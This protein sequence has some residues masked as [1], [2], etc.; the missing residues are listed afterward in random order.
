M[1]GAPGRRESAGRLRRDGLMRVASAGHAVFA[2]LLIFVGIQGLVAGNF[3]VIWQPVPKGVPARGALVY[4]CSAVS[5]ASGIGLLFRRTASA[6]S[7]ALVALLV[8]WFVVWRVPAVFAASL[9]DGTWSCGA[10]LVYLAA[11]WVLFAAFAAD[12][13][14]RL[15]FA[16]GDR[17][18]RIARMLY[19][20]GLIPFGYAHF[21]NAKGT[22]SLVPDWLPWPTAWAYATGVAFVAAGVAILTGTCGR[23]AAALSAS[24]MGSFGL[25]VWVPILS[26]GRA[27]D[28]QWT[29]FETT[30]A[31]TAAG[32]AVA[33][34]YR[35]V[36]WLASRRRDALPTVAYR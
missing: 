29:E 26:A 2:A 1:A 31:L 11:A 12:G 32:W 35:G 17:G 9:I 3:T 16:R 13:T 36:P 24:M 34:S 22:A 25:L 28:F 21:A 23:L 33:D 10:T 19:G 5:L 14:P 7:G 8:L 4:F 15:A 30:L 27:S 18:A 20:V 6:A